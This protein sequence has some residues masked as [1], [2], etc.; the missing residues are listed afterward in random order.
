MSDM[1]HTSGERATLAL[2]S[3]QIKGLRD[4]VRAEF[5]DTQR[6]LDELKPLP[7]AV[8][9]QNERILHSEA[10]LTDLENLN[11]RKREWHAVSLPSLIIGVLG[12][13]AALGSTAA[14]ILT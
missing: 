10:R 1:A 2:V 7:T 6:Q 4:L 9:A 13:L 8:A 14:M 5:K 3:E 11:A 12:L